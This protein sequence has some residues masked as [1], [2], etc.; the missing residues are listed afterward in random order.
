MAVLGLS[1]GHHANEAF[2]IVGTRPL[3]VANGSGHVETVAA[4]L[5]AG[6]DIDAQDLTGWTALHAAAFNGDYATVSLLIQRGALAGE[7]RWYRKSPGDIV[8]M[9]GHA[10]IVDLLQSAHGLHDNE[11]RVAYLPLSTGRRSYG[12][13]ETSEVSFCCMASPAGAPAFVV[14]TRR[15]V[16]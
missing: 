11:Q 1:C 10:K 8:R 16:E 14:S 13:S 2:P 5:D 15:A 7:T 3:I 9:L 4:L 6:A 12:K